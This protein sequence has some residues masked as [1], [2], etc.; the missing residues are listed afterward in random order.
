MNNHSTSELDK[1]RV[2]DLR[3]LA[4][5]H[6][7]IGYSQMRKA[8]LVRLV[9]RHL[10]AMEESKKQ[11]AAERARAYAEMFPG[12]P[13][14]A[15][16][17]SASSTVPEKAEPLPEHDPGAMRDAS[18]YPPELPEAYGENRITLMVR[19]PRWLF[20]YWEVTPRLL[21]TARAEFDGPS[22]K[23]LRVHMLDAD[24][25]VFDGWEQGV[26]DRASNWYLQSNR[27]GTRFRIELGLTDDS[28]RYIRLVIS[29]TVVTPIDS[30][31][32]KWNEEWVGLSRETW[33][34]LERASRPFPGSLA[35]MDFS[36][37]ELKQMVAAHIAGSNLS[38]SRQAG[39]LT[40]S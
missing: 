38:A 9:S 27:P 11:S 7:L 17:A 21:A 12:K 40:E 18:W 6:K 14:A 25:H 16:G 34:Y 19:D 37:T 35:G 15:S 4:R 30:P 39:K 20:C 26:S 31:S 1:L 33:E 22:R 5:E 10:T 24:D 36:R 32:E 2:A 3:A 23:V 13:V 8:D 29:N 28:G